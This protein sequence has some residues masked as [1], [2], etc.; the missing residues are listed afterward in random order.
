MLSDWKASW[1]LTIIATT[2]P[3]T[4]NGLCVLSGAVTKAQVSAA[5][6]WKPISVFLPKFTLLD[7]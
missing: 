1:H 2:I 7:L 6:Q 5:G 4:S 3:Q